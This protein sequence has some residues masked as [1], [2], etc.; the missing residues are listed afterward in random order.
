MTGT[1]EQIRRAMNPQDGS[2]RPPTPVADGVRRPPSAPPNGPRRPRNDTAAYFPHSRPIQR[3]SPPRS[4]RLARLGNLI[5]PSHNPGI[6]FFRNLF[7][8]RRKAPELSGFGATCGLS[9]RNN[10]V[11]FLGRQCGR[12]R[13]EDNVNGTLLFGSR[14]RK[15][16][17]VGPLAG[18]IDGF[19]ALLTS[20]GYAVRT[21]RDKLRLI[22]N[23]SHWMAQEGIGLDA[24]D[25]RRMEAF[26]STR[27]PGYLSRGDAAALHLLLTHLR[28]SGRVGP[29]PTEP[30]GNGPI[31]RVARRN[32]RFLVNERGLSATTVRRYLSVVRAFLADRFGMR[33][34]ELGSLTVRD[35]N[36]FI[37]RG[38]GSVRPGTSKMSATALRS[39]LRHLHQRGEIPADLADGVLPAMNWRRPE[40]PRPL[41]PDGV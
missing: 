28:D 6:P 34:V 23:L 13:G 15:W 29:K 30:D 24:L 19:A 5:N 8:P 18:E 12:R 25:E 35:C 14:S 27:K 37:L 21:A 36:G 3:R 38:S 33:T 10:P 39:F 26:L 31:G 41:D 11:D 7:D 9:F 40:L 2:R 22:R 17:R 32:E 1:G 20:L 16:L 4:T